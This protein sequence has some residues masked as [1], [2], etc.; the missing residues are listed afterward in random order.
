MGWFLV[1]TGLCLLCAVHTE[2]KPTPSMVVIGSVW[3]I[4]CVS[5]IALGVAINKD[6]FF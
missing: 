6:W 5:I 2:G 4:A 1:I 3:I